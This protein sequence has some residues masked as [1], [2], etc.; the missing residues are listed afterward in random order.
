[1]T[2]EGLAKR[3]AMPVLLVRLF[4]LPSQLGYFHANQ[5]PTKEPESWRALRREEG[6]LVVD[7]AQ[8]DE[9]CSSPRESAGA[10]CI[11]G[12]PSISRW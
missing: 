11:A 4:L 5:F 8:T 12:F 10:C 7:H 1:M 6:G 9:R 2:P 3:V